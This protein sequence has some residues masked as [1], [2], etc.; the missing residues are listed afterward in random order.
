MTSHGRWRRTFRAHPVL[1]LAVTLLPLAGLVFGSGMR[2]G[3]APPPTSSEP[4]QSGEGAGLA[5]RFGWQW[6][7]DSPGTVL[8]PS[9]A[10]PTETG[11]ALTV[12]KGSLNIEWAWCR[13]RS[14]DG[15]LVVYGKVTN[16]GGEAINLILLDFSFYDQTGSFM[17]NHTVTLRRLAAHGTTKIEE[18]LPSQY[19]EWKWTAWSMRLA[20]VDAN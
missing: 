10:A 13:S 12:Q 4:S 3:T 5:G 20:S 17:G 7:R 16:T 11:S 9:K 2:A 14:S 19:A 8:L 6:C 18:S 1:S 15:L